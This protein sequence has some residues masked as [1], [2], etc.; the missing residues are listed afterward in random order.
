MLLEFNNLSPN[1]R[2]W[3]F[4]TRN[5]IS[6]SILKNLKI[7]LNNICENWTSHGKAIKSSYKIKEKHFIIFF[8]EEKDMSGCSID[9]SNR[10][11]L[12]L[13]NALNIDLAPNSKIGIFKGERIYFYNKEEIIDLINKNKFSLSNYMINTTIRNKKEYLNEWKLILKDS[14][15]K[16]FIK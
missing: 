16:N 6:N 8:A 15:L 13:L 5:E 12:K 11:L 4:I 3:V 10:E 9:S 2:C 14:W 1:S 7:G